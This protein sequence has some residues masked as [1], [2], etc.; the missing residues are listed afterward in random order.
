[1]L[2]L[3]RTTLHL[4]CALAV[5][6]AAPGCIT[7]C[8]VT[9]TTT[10]KDLGITVGLATLELGVGLLGG[11]AVSKQ[12]DADAAGTI[13]PM[14]SVPAGLLLA[15]AIIALGLYASDH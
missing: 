2:S 14:I 12:D 8:T 1:M 4:A 6:C 3:Q 13:N 15:D 10:Y 7:Y 5:A 11:Y 9:K